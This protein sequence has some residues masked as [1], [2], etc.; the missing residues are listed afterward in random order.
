MTIKY[1]PDKRPDNLDTGDVV[2]LSGDQYAVIFTVMWGRKKGQS[3]PSYHALMI[4]PTNNKVGGFGKTHQHIKDGL[5]LGMIL[6]PSSGQNYCFSTSPQKILPSECAADGKGNAVFLGNIIDTNL[7][8]KELAPT[9]R[10]QV[11]VRAYL[12]GVKEP[13]FEKK[14]L[15]RKQGREDKRASASILKNIDL[16]LRDATDL[17]LFPGEYTHF[18]TTLFKGI[19]LETTLRAAL[20]VLKKT[21][22]QEIISIGSNIA[23]GRIYRQNLDPNSAVESGYLP[24]DIPALVR[25]CQLAEVSTLQEILRKI[26][27]G[28]LSRG[29]RPDEMVRMREHFQQAVRKEG[30]DCIGE[31][32]GSIQTLLDELPKKVAQENSM[33]QGLITVYPVR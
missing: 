29:F 12:M 14:A 28:E 1:S 22:K 9:F 20:S 33:F 32:R 27:S 30:Q 3:V 8:Q 23:I 16:S 2:R 13:V 15:P 18:L 7:F 5:T 26:N 19:N 21:P 24:H 17:Q 31:I 25:G 10:K 6:G 4:E 11:S